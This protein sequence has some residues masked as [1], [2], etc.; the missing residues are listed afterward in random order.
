MAEFV[1]YARCVFAF[2]EGV[3]EFVSD[4]TGVLDGRRVII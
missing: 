3:E 2:G 1:H 4:L